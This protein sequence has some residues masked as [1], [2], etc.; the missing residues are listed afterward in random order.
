LTCFLSLGST[1]LANSFLRSS[2]EFADEQCFP[3]DVYFCHSCS[4]VQL[5]DVVDPEVLFRDYI[6]VSGTSDAVVSHN[7]EYAQTVVE[8]QGLKSEDLVV[9]VASNDGSLLQCFKPYG[10]R[11]LGIEPATNIAEMA[12]SK[13]IETINEFFNSATAGKVRASY[14]PARVVIGN[15]VLAHVDEVKDFLFGCKELLDDSGLV[16]VEVPYLRTLIDGMEYDTVYHEHLSY[17]SVTSLLKLCEMV[18]LSIVR[19]DQMSIHGG[20]LRVY[21]GLPERYGDHSEMASSMAQ[22]EQQT[23]ATGLAC[24]K[25]FASRVERNRQEI[26]HLLGSLRQNG[27]SIAGYGAPAK[28]NTLLNY[29]GIGTDLVPYTVDKNPMKVGLY[30]PGMHIPVLPADEI[31]ARQPDFVLILAWNF[32][33]E[34]MK[35]Q[36]EYY[37]RGGRFIVPVPEPKVV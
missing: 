13:G 9:E 19:I 23:G 34:I 1:P 24:Y 21:A 26:C 27:K 12:Y 32:A 3:L 14:G 5:L 33:G 8:L 36:Q 29:C 30:T 35:Q 31:L 18:G 11:L 2:D 17:F 10:I 4:L 28:G 16:V 22:E 37:R 25:Q 6:Y 7:R 20:S 15:N